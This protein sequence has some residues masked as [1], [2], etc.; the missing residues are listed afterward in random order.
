MYEI[1]NIITSNNDTI[2]ILANKIAH[3]KRFYTVRIFDVRTSTK[4]DETRLFPNDK[5]KL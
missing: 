5:T 1:I 3:Q 2:V 4:A